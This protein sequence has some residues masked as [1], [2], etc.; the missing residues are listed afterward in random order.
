MV[1]DP[2]DAASFANTPL[3]IETGHLPRLLLRRVALL[4]F[5]VTAVPLVLAQF[6]PVHPEIVMWAQRV[7]VVPALL[8]LFMRRINV[9]FASWF[10]VVFLWLLVTACVIRYTGPGGIMA[11]A[12][13]VVTSV[14]A[15]LL[16][17]RFWLPILVASLVACGALVHAEYAGNWQPNGFDVDDA[18]L[19]LTI[20]FALLAIASLLIFWGRDQV[21][22]A[23]D[24][25]R[26]RDGEL[27]EHRT[28]VD[29]RSAEL[30]ANNARLQLESQQRRQSMEQLRQTEMALR[31]SEKRYRAVFDHDP[32]AVIIADL[33][34]QEIVDANPSAT[35]L[36]G[37]ERDE[38][39]RMTVP[40]LSP[41][42]QPKWTDEDA[43]LLAID[44]ATFHN[45][46]VYE[47]QFESASGEQFPAEVRL[48]RLPKTANE[49]QYFQM[50][51]VDIAERRYALNALRESEARY[52]T[53]VEKAPDAIVI[54]D[55]DRQA[56]VEANENAALLFGTTISDLLTADLAE[57]M[58][59]DADG[60]FQSF[61]DIADETADGQQVTI[62]FERPDS[63]ET[64]MTLEAH[65]IK[66]PANNR[67][68]LRASMVSATRSRR[69]ED[70]VAALPGCV[71]VLSLDGNVIW[72]NTAFVERF[73]LDPTRLNHVSIR[74]FISTETFNAML[75]QLR[76]ESGRRRFTLDAQTSSGTPMRLNASTLIIEYQNR[77]AILFMPEEDAAVSD[78]LELSDD[79]DDARNAVIVS[80]EDAQAFK[81][82]IGIMLN[83]A[84]IAASKLPTDNPARPHLDRSLEAAKSFAQLSRT[85]V[86]EPQAAR[87]TVTSVNVNA[88][89][90]RNRKLF[91]LTIPHHL[92]IDYALAHALPEIHADGDL[93]KR[94]VAGLII[95][96]AEAIGDEP[97][98]IVVETESVMISAET[99]APYITHTGVLLKPG[100]YVGITI[101]DNGDG[102]N[103]A[104]L[105]RLFDPTTGGKGA[106]LSAIVR[107]VR[108]HRGG[109]RVT[110]EE[111]IGTSLTL[112]F[113][114]V[115]T[116]I[117]SMS[118]QQPSAS[119]GMPSA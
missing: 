50:S 32:N 85:T 73:D 62:E 108:G 47:W 3:E 75:S 81:E 22:N 9:A 37:Y 67:N 109:L 87:I 5:V 100:R 52:R 92:S 54:I 53:L 12:Y 59:L 39:L 31:S 76:E 34:S 44:K 77:A 103:S 30:A 114:A 70:I 4:L 36:F 79:Q 1:A 74:R 21:S 48:V 110:S 78:S 60:P 82:L 46:S 13:L 115:S 98:L 89:I 66:M 42:E 101:R 96:A 68:L 69:A 64:P 49:E 26:D 27:D 63:A 28:L 104:T 91:E 10:M 117:S 6:M 102:Y 86:G 40:Q 106:R 41:D 11:T 14:S 24:A 18:W 118:G 56:I 97:G 107:V 83:H 112:V 113:P 72:A 20:Q 93:V 58:P 90:D 2:Q 23:I 33:V 65:I 80:A 43:D 119:T 16:P 57:L 111:G 94:M 19:E 88:L 38:L 7:L 35:R 51:I 55:V 61:S 25:L 8:L 45:L 29:Q 105:S 95:N 84:T 116:V 15:A 71:S 17:K 99:Q